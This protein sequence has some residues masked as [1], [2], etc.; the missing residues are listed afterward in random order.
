MFV[1]IFTT[2]ACNLSNAFKKSKLEIYRPSAIIAHTI[3]GKGISFMEENNNWHYR[4]PNQEELE[5]ALKE[6]E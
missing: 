1:F 2:I 5:N 6:I 3:K 4:T